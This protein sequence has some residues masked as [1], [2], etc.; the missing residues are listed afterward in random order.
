MPYMVNAMQP[1]EMDPFLPG[2]LQGQRNAQM[3]SLLAGLANARAM[4]ESNRTNSLSALQNDLARN[5]T[6]RYRAE[7]ERIGT[8][9]Q[10][11]LGLRQMGN[12]RELGLGEQDVNRMQILA[13]QNMLQ[14]QM[15]NNRQMG[16]DKMGMM[17]GI[18]GQQG[19]MAKFQAMIQAMAQGMNPDMAAALFGSDGQMT[20][21]KLAAMK[22]VQQE[23]KQ[24]QANIMTPPIINNLDTIFANNKASE[25]IWQTPIE[26]F[27]QRL[28]EAPNAQEKFLTEVTGQNKV[29]DN[30]LPG[31]PEY[32]QLLTVLNNTIRKLNGEVGMSWLLPQN[33]GFSGV[34]DGQ[35][36]SVIPQL[37][38]LQALIQNQTRQN[39]AGMM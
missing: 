3:T 29:P 2:Q 33:I 32:A 27:G 11:D 8:G 36:K 1:S 26:F 6:D 4:A 7:S 20:P 31:S 14:S 5:D 30:L 28:A 25:G 21:D 16:L 12:Q 23:D 24:K 22:R 38:Q 18:M 17:Q 39:A 10:Y 37:Q 19:Q 13:Q 9:S 34:S 15:N 35:I